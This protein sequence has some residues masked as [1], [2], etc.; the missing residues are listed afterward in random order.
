MLQAEVPQVRDRRADAA[1]ARRLGLQLGP[2][3]VEPQHGQEGA[4]RRRAQ[5]QLGGRRHLRLPPPLAR[6][7]QDRLSEQEEEV[8]HAV[9]PN[10]QIL[11]NFN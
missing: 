4:R 8:V 10:K 1:A 7:D 2:V 9:F 6:A 3:A 11:K 5:A